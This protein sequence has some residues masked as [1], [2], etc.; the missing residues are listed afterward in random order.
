MSQIGKVLVAV[1]GFIQALFGSNPT[2]S[3]V[4]AFLEAVGEGIIAGQGSVGPIRIGNL[5]LTV[6]IAPWSGTPTP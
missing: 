1:G 3:E 5:G 2:W 6:S 4:G